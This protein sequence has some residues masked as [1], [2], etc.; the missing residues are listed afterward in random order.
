MKSL[1]PFKTFQ[2]L[3]F[4][5]IP[6]LSIREKV[7]PGDPNERAHPYIVA[8]TAMLQVSDFHSRRARGL[9]KSRACSSR[10]DRVR[11]NKTQASRCYECPPL[12][13]RCPLTKFRAAGCA[14]FQ[15][16]SSDVVWSVQT[17]FTIWFS[18][19]KACLRSHS[20]NRSIKDDRHQPER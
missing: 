8:A 15:N 18:W 3:S 17:D 7:P 4:F 19:S 5:S 16:E 9:W 13:S 12:T 6:I 10:T 14:L 20:H 11:V 1:K 2:F